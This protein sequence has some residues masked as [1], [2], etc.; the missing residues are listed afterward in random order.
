MPILTGQ[1]VCKAWEWVLPKC[2]LERFHGLLLHPKELVLIAGVV[3]RC[4][5]MKRTRLSTMIHKINLCSSH[6]VEMNLS[7]F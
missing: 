3:E 1:I 7:Q 2:A 4:A 6:C 5:F